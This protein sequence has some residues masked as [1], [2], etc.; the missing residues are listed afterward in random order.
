MSKQNLAFLPHLIN[1][2][3]LFTKTKA[4]GKRE[5]EREKSGKKRFAFQSGNIYLKEK[6][7][8]SSKEIRCKQNWAGFEPVA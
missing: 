3:R 7:W 2:L 8:M 6:C 5:R 4:K 1:I